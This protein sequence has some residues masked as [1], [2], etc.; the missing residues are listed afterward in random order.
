MHNSQLRCCTVRLRCWRTP[1]QG[2]GRRSL[3]RGP[4][5]HGGFVWL[6]SWCGISLGCELGEGF[7]ECS[8][9][10]ALVGF[11]FAPSPPLI[12]KPRRGYTGG[13][14]FFCLSEN[15]IALAM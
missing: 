5:A 2:R 15:Q 12:E 1:G 6:F 10:V 14:L 13:I 9:S 8:G 11:V 7:H 3:P 4:S